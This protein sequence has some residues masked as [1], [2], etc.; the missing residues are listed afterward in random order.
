VPKHLPFAWTFVAAAL[1]LFAAS[2]AFAQQTPRL[3]RY[4]DP[5]PPSA[6]LRLGTTRLQTRGG[7]AWMPDGKSLITQKRG[8]VFVWDLDDG[9]CRETLSV[10]LVA[11]PFFTYGS[12]LALSHDG[13]RLVCTDFH[14][15]IAVW[16]LETSEM[17]S[18]PAEDIKKNDEN[19]ALAIRPDGK[20]F[21]TLR[22][23]GE[24]QFRDMA[25]CEVARTVKLPEE[26]W[27]ESTRVAHSPDGKIIAIAGGFQTRAIY[28]VRDGESAVIP[29]AH[30][31][32]LINVHFLPD[33][34][35]LSVGT[36]KENVPPGG[37]EPTHHSQVRIWDLA[38]L[39]LLSEWPLGESRPEG[40]SV[41]FSTDGRT[42]TSVHRDRISVWDVA[43]QKVVR[44]I[45]GLVFSNPAY[46]QVAIDP[47]GKY[48]AVNDRSNYVRLWN[49]AT[50]QP[51][52]ST[53]QQHQR[54]VSAADW[55]P[56]GKTILTSDGQGDVRLWSAADGRQVN[57]FRGPGWGAFTAQ[58]SPS[59]KEIVVCG[60]DYDRATQKVIGK[61]QWV[62]AHSGKR[63]REHLTAGRARLAT[64]SPDQSLVVAAV[65]GLIPEEDGAKLSLTVFDAASGQPLFAIE[66]GSQIVALHWTS[67]GKQLLSCDNQALMIMDVAAGRAVLRVE[68]PHFRPDGKGGLQRGG[69]S[70]AVFTP[71]GSTLITSSGN[72]ELY[73]WSKF[74]GQK[75]WT[76][77]VVGPYFRA[78]ALSP[79]ESIVACLAHEDDKKPRQL[80]LVDI[81]SQRELGHYDL[82]IEGVNC[83]AFSPDGG[84]VVVGF[85][86]GNAVVYDVTAAVAKQ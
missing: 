73:G 59:A 67:D 52:L 79:D 20:S 2:A 11:N 44:T 32:S 49:L 83:L 10:P 70:R 55:S 51:L 30:S 17:V 77:P 71:R 33:G 64:P 61:I 41:A 40:C 62:D 13:Q 19:V 48:V 24:L 86:D 68:L 12:Q 54:W 65:G 46:A 42:M 60:D 82:G 72:S 23:N 43:T 22:Q 56:D 53:D 38:E 4:G 9:H 14:G 29:K 84:K 25:T 21:V 66:T 26:H 57:Q 1:T 85:D 39:R 15:T 63:L 47:R 31:G 76:I 6:V 36:N 27:R 34:Q 5:L 45:E 81:A 50:G 16:N 37:G 78:L 58:F 69:P 80:R 74:T 75:L 28:R 8:T 7:F 18:K 35:L 3:D